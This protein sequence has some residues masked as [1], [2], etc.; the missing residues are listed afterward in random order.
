M[1]T[2]QDQPSSLSRT[3]AVSPPA[4]RASHL[5]VGRAE[6]IAS[7]LTGSAITYYAVK[8]PGLGGLLSG[9]VGGLLLWR[10]ATGYCPIHQALGWDTAH[11]QTHQVEVTRSLRVNR[12]RPQVYQFWRQLE[13]LP[14]FMHYLEDVRPLGPLRSHW[15]ARLPSGLGKI[16][17]QADIIREEEN[18]LIVWRSQPG[19]DIDNAGEV[20]FSDDPDRQGTLVQAIISY[21]PPAGDVGELAARLLNPTFQEWV[22]QDLLRFKRL[23]ENPD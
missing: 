13:N 14:R 21:R 10:G 12:P 17:W 22:E 8:N 9:L 5:N 4:T 20:R 2:N 16:E 19:S 1:K 18:A 3:T 6:R 7:V 11:R 15:V 23:L